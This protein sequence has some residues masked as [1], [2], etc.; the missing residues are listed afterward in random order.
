MEI[1]EQDLV[2][3]LYIQTVGF[4]TKLNTK[5]KLTQKKSLKL[6]YDQYFQFHN[7]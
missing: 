1:K 6:I 7:K 4:M 3:Q 2:S 5:K